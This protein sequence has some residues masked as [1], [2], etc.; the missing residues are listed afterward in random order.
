MKWLK[1]NKGFNG[2]TR[3][4][5]IY[6]GLVHGSHCKQTKRRRRR[7]EGMITVEFNVHLSAPSASP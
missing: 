2:V 4:D 7:R 5:K 3:M 1:G 6:L